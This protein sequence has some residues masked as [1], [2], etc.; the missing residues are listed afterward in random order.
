M[1]EGVQHRWKKGGGQPRDRGK[2]GS[3]Q[4]HNGQ[5]KWSYTY[6]PCGN[7]HAHQSRRGTE[8]NQGTDTTKASLPLGYISKPCL[9]SC[10]QA[11]NPK[12][13]LFSHLF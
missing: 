8:L 11:E 2:H 7:S 6:N 12:L 10:R 13:F 3:F 9:L 5:H 1:P 4:S